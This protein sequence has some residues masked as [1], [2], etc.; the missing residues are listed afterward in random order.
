MPP[1]GSERP[2]PTSA[3][4]IVR[5]RM[6]LLSSDMRSRALLLMTRRND[7]QAKR[8]L[9]ETKRIIS[10]ISASLHTGPPLSSTS[11]Q[12]QPPRSNGRR[13][14]VAQSLA[15]QTLQACAE[16]VGK[17][18]EGCLQRDDF[19]SHMRYTAA[20]QAVVLRDQRA[21]TPKSATERL[22]WTADNSLWLVGRSQQWIDS[23]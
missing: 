7:S 16:D 22:F 4:D 17:V 8:L 1:S 20:Q 21:W 15:Q 14:S 10:T 18:L 5:R 3:P 11:S 19:E 12:L 6:E 23:R 2:Q 9:E 13:G